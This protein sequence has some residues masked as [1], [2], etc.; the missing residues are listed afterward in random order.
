MINLAVFYGGRTSEHDVSIITGTQLI[1]NA[2]KTKYNIMPVYISRKGEWYA[3]LPLADAR[4]Y[5]NPDLDKKGVY[6]VI[7]S[8]VAGSRELMKKTAF[9]LKSVFYIDAAVIAMHGMHGE[10]GTLQ[11]FFELAD[12]PYTSA[13][14]TGSAAG[15]DKI[16]MKAAFR[17]LGLPVLDCVYFERAEYI[18]DRDAIFAKVEGAFTYPVI[19]KPANLGSSIGITRANDRE[20]LIAGIDVAIHYDRRV[21]VE[22][23][24]EDLTEI[25]CA[26]LGEGSDA[27]ASFLEQPVTA[28]A[29]LD[30]S[31]KYLKGSASKGMKSLERILPRKASQRNGRK[32]QEVLS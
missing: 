2:D 12:L 8:P 11:G 17:G 5:L 29:V 1:E 19:V 27:V 3:G 10:D 9:G 21:L 16:V 28:K 15:M 30:F 18:Q 6:K 22:R 14:I 24:I 32:D 7:L 31:E 23:A 26:V 13:G 25:N 20:G 4:F